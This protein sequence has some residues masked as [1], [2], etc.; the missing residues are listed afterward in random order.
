MRKKQT[1]LVGKA[2]CIK[3][4]H[5]LQHS[6]PPSLVTLYCSFPLNGTDAG[7]KWNSSLLMQTDIEVQIEK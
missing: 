1:R 6:S 3:T 5:I 4:F 7:I 2:D